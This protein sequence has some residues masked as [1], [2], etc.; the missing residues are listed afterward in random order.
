VKSISFEIDLFETETSPLSKPANDEEIADL[1]AL[2]LK[3]DPF[4]GMD[5]ARE[6]RLRRLLGVVLED[7]GA[8]RAELGEQ[9][10]ATIDMDD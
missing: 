1:V 3:D 5:E 4:D 10:E 8:A 7:I 9:D 6:R 2:L